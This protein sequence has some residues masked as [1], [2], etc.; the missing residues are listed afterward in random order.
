VFETS[1]NVGL[2]VQSSF[3]Q[4]HLYYLCFVINIYVVSLPLYTLYV[5]IVLVSYVEVDFHLLMRE[6]SGGN[7]T[8]KR[9]SSPQFIF[10]FI[11]LNYIIPFV[12]YII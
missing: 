6:G 4:S 2:L 1:S 9:S 12:V 7:M 10:N 11:L 8:G 3:L 5:C